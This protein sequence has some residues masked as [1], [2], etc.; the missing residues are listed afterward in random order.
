MVPPIAGRE[1]AIVERLS[2]ALPGWRVRGAATGITGAGPSDLL[3]PRE[4]FI[5]LE[6]H[7]PSGPFAGPGGVTTWRLEFS[8]SEVADAVRRIGN[9]G[10]A[11]PL[12]LFPSARAAR[13]RLHGWSPLDGCGPLVSL[14]GGLSGESR[15]IATWRERFAEPLGHGTAP[16]CF[17]TP[18]T[19]LATAATPAG[20]TVVGTIAPAMALHDW[21]AFAQPAPATTPACLGHVLAVGDGSV[22]V[23]SPLPFDL[24]DGGSIL[25]AARLASVPTGFTTPVRHVGHQPLGRAE[26]LAG[27]PATTV[28]GTPG[29]DIDLVAG[30][31]VLAQAR[32]LF[33]WSRGEAGEVLAGDGSGEA[34][35]C[36]QRGTP[37]LD[38]LA[39]GIAS[40]A[41]ALR[42][43]PAPDLAGATP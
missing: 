11:S 12:G 10:D 21:L 6:S 30:P 32:A 40:V 16:V 3:G 31:L 24:P 20:S 33:D 38:T 1:T 37:R 17:G 14:G 29:V 36:A 2:L 22:T 26:T 7:D 27:T 19:V 42:L 43:R 34:W 13:E 28:L 4:V 35:R 41:L 23:E 8:S 18:Q 15:R 9:P 25:I 39:P 5:I